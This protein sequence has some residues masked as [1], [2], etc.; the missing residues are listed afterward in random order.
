MFVGTVSTVISWQDIRKTSKGNCGCSCGLCGPILKPQQVLCPVGA[1]FIS[2]SG[3]AVVEVAAVEAVEAAGAAAGAVAEPNDG[4]RDASRDVP[5]QARVLCREPR[6]RTQ[7]MR[8]RRRTVR[9]SCSWEFSFLLM[10]FR[11]QLHAPMMPPTIPPITVAP[12]A[13]HPAPS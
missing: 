10:C 6:V 8:V 1:G 4:G 11:S 5:D 12:R 2:K 7:R 3:Q 13:T 9:V